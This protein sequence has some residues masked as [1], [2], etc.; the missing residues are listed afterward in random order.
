MTRVQLRPA[1]GWIVLVVLTVWCAPA[2]GQHEVPDFY[3]DSWYRIAVDAAG[4]MVE[5]DGYGYNGGTWYYYP[6]TGWY[7]QWFY[8]GPYDPARRGELEYKAYITPGPSIGPTDIEMEFNWTTP[9]W[10]A[11]GLGSP[12][13]SDDV[14]NPSDESR[15]IDSQGFHSTYGVS[16]F[17]SIEPNREI[18]VDDYNPEWTCIAIRGRNFRVYRWAI[19]R[20]LPKE[21]AQGA[22]CDYETGDCYI[23]SESE[24]RASY[25]WLGAGST[26][27]A[28]TAKPSTPMDFGDAPDPG[29]PT[30]LAHNGARHAI[31][32]GVFL[33]TRVDAETNG[34]PNAS[35]TGDDNDGI[36]DED[37]VT[38]TSSIEPGKIAT[39]DVTASVQ[40]Y[41]NAWIDFNGNG[42]FDDAGEQI[43]SDEPLISGINGLAFVVPDAAREGV[44]F[45][46]FRFN[47]RGLLSSNGPA[48]D[49]EV[50]DYR[51][52]I[53]TG[54]E[55]QPTSGLTTAQWSQPPS[56]LDPTDP[57]TFDGFMVLSSFDRHQ[58]AADD[59]RFEDSQPITGIHWWG[60]FDG[61]TQ[62]HLPPRLPLAF[63]IAIWSDV[64]DPQPGNPN[65][66]N[67]PGTLLWETYSTG[68]T[69]A[70]A[71][72]QQDEKAGEARPAVFQF[73]QG[74]SQDEWFYPISGAA[75]G[76]PQSTFFW[77]SI[78]ALYDPQ[79]APPEH[80]W[81]WMSRTHESG[82]AAVIVDD[83]VPADL[84][85]WPPTPGAQ[86]SVGTV[87]QDGT[88]SP[89]DL[90]FQLTSFRSP[91]PTGATVK[92]AQ[93]TARS[94]QETD[95][96]K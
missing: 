89:L 21:A 14:A 46:R 72:H 88:K 77:V 35:A 16:G 76:N 73:T 7:R 22:W 8:N 66:F 33:G 1:F 75:G 43:F 84:A 49:G 24:G 70:V 10:S 82:A 41:L 81:G 48:T 28:C 39:L 58:I 65:T 94:R 37:G 4:E 50:E 53:V 93:T 15:Y 31:V 17:T 87:A 3:P 18:T 52:T 90:A 40:G 12:P 56:L 30:L 60:S 36:D 6:E 79:E 91:Y 95:G 5:G 62:P 71:G 92:I 26:C 45:G 55:P 85:P 27:Q 11:L 19:H 34:Q 80:P 29:Y 96:T 78:A 54:F 51:L 59:C 32:S 67:H 13:M 69:W 20:C 57:F 74:L 63:H 25:T 44:T 42:V 47:T 64:P 23:G 83:I 61:W 9:E 68:S 38:F 86:W 2:R